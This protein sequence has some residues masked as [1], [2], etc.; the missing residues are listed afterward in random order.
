V[1]KRMTKAEAI[2]ALDAID[3]FGDP[4]RAHSE[5]DGILLTFVGE[6]VAAAYN[7]LAGRA[8]WWAGA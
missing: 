2:A 1:A 8:P 6:E 3:P 4:E 5:A 7:A